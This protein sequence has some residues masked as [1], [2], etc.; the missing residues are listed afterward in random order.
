[1]QSSIHRRHS[2]HGKP[3]NAGAPRGIFRSQYEWTH[4]LQEGGQFTVTRV[5]SVVPRVL[6]A[7]YRALHKLSKMGVSELTGPT[8]QRYFVAERCDEPRGKV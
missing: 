2:Q 1:M 7:E 8:Y 3:V 5:G 4:L 6:S